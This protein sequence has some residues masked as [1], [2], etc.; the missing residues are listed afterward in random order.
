MLWDILRIRSPF[1]PKLVKP[2]RMGVV[3]EPGHA[4]VVSGDM[5]YEVLL[6][7]NVEL[8]TGHNDGGRKG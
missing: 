2:R 7:C 1:G 3:R 8:L 6:R 5:M 4:W